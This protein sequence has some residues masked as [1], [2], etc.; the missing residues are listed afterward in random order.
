[1]SISEVANG[2]VAKCRQGDFLG[3]LDAYYASNIVS[4]E[5][6]GSPEM[7]AEMEGIDAVRGKSEWWVENHEVHSIALEGPYIGKDGFAVYFE[8]DVTNKPSGQRFQ[9]SEMARYAVADG[10]I[11]REEFYY[12][13]PGAD[14]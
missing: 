4:V 7:P 14:T 13:A 2:L 11:V 6:V 12:N 3:A 5:P 8:M 10:K 1:M 9:M